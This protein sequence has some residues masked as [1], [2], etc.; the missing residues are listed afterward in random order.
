LRF[1]QV[2]IKIPLVSGKNLLRAALAPAALVL[3]GGLTMGALA[4]SSAPTNAAHSGVAAPTSIHTTRTPARIHR[5]IS[6]SPRASFSAQKGTATLKVHKGGSG[7]G[8]VTSDPAGINCGSEC[9]H[10]FTRGTKV[11]LTAAAG[12][13][14]Y[15]KGWLANCLNQS[16]SRLKAYVTPTCDVRVSGPTHAVALFGKG[17]GTSKLLV[18]KS[19]NGAGKITSDPA[20]ISCGSA[21]SHSYA[22]DTEVTL[23]AKAASGSVFKTWAG[24]CKG[25]AKS[26]LK[27]Y[28]NPTCQVKVS[29]N[30][31]VKAIFVTHGQHHKHKHHKHHKHHHK[32]HGH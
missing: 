15:F 19:G 3:F 30:L 10:A 5:A 17:N 11:T 22:T 8:T 27:A 24:D 29:H 23:K 7:S 6:S 18:S 31:H 1:I 25:E 13:G 2:S 9:S 14:S 26:R 16:S 20:G 12:A 28:K 4:L 21:C 32:H